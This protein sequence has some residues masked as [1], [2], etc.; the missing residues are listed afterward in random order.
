M[1]QTT[2]AKNACN[3]VL[4]VDNASGVL[5]DISGSSNQA[6]ISISTNISE[7][8]TF[9]GDWGIKKACKSTAQISLSLV[10]STTDTEALNIIKDW[11]FNAPTTSRTVQISI[12][13]NTAGSDQYSGEFVLEGIDIPIDASDAGVILVSAS[14]SND[15][16]FSVAT[17]AS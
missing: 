17:I 10:Y 14:L 15:G 13:D 2:T 12:P 6:S 8:F 4:E 7:V 3:V 16:A 11:K 9:D 5:T 1:A